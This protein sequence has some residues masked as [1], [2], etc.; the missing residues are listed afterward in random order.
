MQLVFSDTLMEDEDLYRFLGDAV[1]NLGVPMAHIAEGRTPWQVFRDERFLGNSRVD[2]CSKILKRHLLDKWVSDNFQPADTVLYV[3]ID[4]SEMHRLDRLQAGRAPWKVE[5]PLCDPPYLNKT[6]LLNWAR[7]EG[8]RPPRL[9]ELG[10]PHN[11]CGG[12]CIKAGQA[13]FAK[14]LREMPERYAFHEGKEESMRDLLGDVSILRDRTG[15][16]TKPLT[17]R[18]LRERIQSGAQIDLFDWGGCG[19]Y[20]D[21]PDGAA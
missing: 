3:G 21:E 11:N 1:L 12:F 2:P 19:C 16:E 8:L 9:Y 10:F 4:W 5:A 15:G 18:Q 20:V 17:L 7:S 6:D 14:L 13:Q